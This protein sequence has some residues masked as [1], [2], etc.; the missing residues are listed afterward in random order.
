MSL[1]EEHETET[2]S[3]VLDLGFGLTRP[4]QLQLPTLGFRS[5][6]SAT[7]ALCARWCVRWCVR[8]RLLSVQ[9]IHTSKSL[10]MEEK[11]QP[12]DAQR[13]LRKQP[14][15][16]IYLFPFCFLL[17]IYALNIYAYAHYFCI[18]ICSLSVSSSVTPSLSPSLSHTNTHTNV[19]TPS[20]SR[21]R[22]SSSFN[23]AHTT[24]RS[25]RSF[26][27]YAHSRHL[28]ATINNRHRSTRYAHTQQHT[29]TH[30]SM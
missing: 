20:R 8:M 9:L 13:H 16:L 19:Q 17:R 7:P 27:T 24:L 21:L 5:M 30:K 11:P 28:S 18:H 15:Q 26:F 25:S 1:S 2:S 3:V 29:Q 22:R 10:R 23:T 4:H 12:I 14:G 6:D